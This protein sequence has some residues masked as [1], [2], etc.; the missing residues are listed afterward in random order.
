M[1]WIRKRGNSYALIEGFREHGKVKQRYVRTLTRE[2]AEALMAVKGQCPDPVPPRV[3]HETVAPVQPP[4]ASSPLRHDTTAAIAP[5]SL[6]TTAPQAP[7][8]PPIEQTWCQRCGKLLAL[9]GTLCG[10]CTGA[11]LLQ[12]PPPVCERCRQQIPYGGMG[13]RFCCQGCLTGQSHSEDCDLQS[14]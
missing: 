2:E 8:P 5:S 14:G 9:G 11:Y 4:P 10:Q 1:S 6:D 3:M 13:Q 12:P 7:S